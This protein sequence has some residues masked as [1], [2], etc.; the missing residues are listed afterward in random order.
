ME[1]VYMDPS[2]GFTLKE[3]KA[4]KLEKMLYGLK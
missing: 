1:D 3:G 2:S 4:C